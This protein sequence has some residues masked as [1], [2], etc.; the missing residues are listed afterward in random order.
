[1]ATLSIPLLGTAFLLVLIM[2]GEH[3]T[4]VARLLCAIGLH[5][6]PEHSISVRCRVCTRCEKREHARSAEP[7]PWDWH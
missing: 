6:W 3:N 2:L 1:M 4:L 5:V 7:H